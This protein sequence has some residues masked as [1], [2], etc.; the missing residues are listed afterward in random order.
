M[1]SQLVSQLTDG[2]R[3]CLRGVWRHLESKEIAIELSISHHTVDAR[4]KHAMRTLGV[5]TRRQA[6]ALVAAH[7]NLPAYQPLVSQTPDL[8]ETHKPPADETSA[9]GAGFPAP[10]PTKRRPKNDLTIAQR[11]GWIVALTALSILALGVL[12]AG[13]VALSQ[14]FSR[15]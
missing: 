13:M 2:Q 5:S 10:V 15:H 1:D 3:A 7:E 12:L 4:I 8:S 9:K 6:A 11:L 14:T